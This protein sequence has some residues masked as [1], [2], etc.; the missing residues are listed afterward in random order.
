MSDKA[1]R[2]VL[3]GRGEPE[4]LRLVWHALNDSVIAE[5]LSVSVATMKNS[6]HSACI[7]LGTRRRP[8][9]RA[10]KRPHASTQPSSNPPASDPRQPSDITKW[11][12]FGLTQV[13]PIDLSS[14]MDAIMVAISMCDIRPGYRSSDFVAP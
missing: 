6:T 1:R 7:K 11:L 9:R 4:V 12:H 5:Q 3:T 8:E 10:Q 2:T 14:L 13:S